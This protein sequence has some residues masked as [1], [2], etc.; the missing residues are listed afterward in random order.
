MNFAGT[1][2]LRLVNSFDQ[3]D[4]PGPDRLLGG[5]I[6]VELTRLFHGRTAENLQ[7]GREQSTPDQYWMISIG[8]YFYDGSQPGQVLRSRAGRLKRLGSFIAPPRRR[9]KVDEGPVPCDRL[10]LA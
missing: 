9:L 4:G 2:T 10:A 3:F 6:Y 7:C 1:T 5:G 8:G